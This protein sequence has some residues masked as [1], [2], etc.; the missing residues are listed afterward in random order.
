MCGIAGFIGAG[1]QSDLARMSDALVHRGP[2]G[3]GTF[4]DEELKVFLAH[5]RLAILDIAGGEQPMW[6]EDRKVC[7]T[8]NG[9]I[10]NAPEL[11][12]ELERAGH[13][14]ESDH[15][16]TE[17]LVH[18]W[19]QWGRDLPAKLNG[20]FA[21]A[22]LDRGQ[23][24]LFLARDRFGEKPLYYTQ[25]R[26]FFGF[27]SEL[28]SLVAHSRVSK[29][30][31]P[32]A[33]CKFFAYGYIP[34]PNAIVEG[35][36]KLPGGYWLSYNFHTQELITR[37]YWHFVIEPDPSITDAD[38]P[39]LIEE[40]RSLLLS[41]AQRRLVSDVPIGSFLSGGLDSSLVLASLA[42]G[43]PS[44]DLSTFTIGFQEPS[45]DES[46]YA[47]MVAAQFGT[48]HHERRL[49]IERARELIPEVLGRLDE[50]LG[51]ASLLPTYLLSAFTRE[52]VKVALTGDGGDE[53]FAGYDPF[54]ALNPAAV[55]DRL[56]PSWAHRSVRRLVDLLP[57]SDANMTMDF[58]LRRTLM[59]IEAPAAA[60][61]P[62]WMAP[63]DPKDLK[64]A[65]ESALDVREIYGE[66][67]ELWETD[68]SKSTT[69]R[70][71][72]FFTRFYL[73]DDI[74]AKADRAS[75]MCS[76]ETRAV[77]LDNDL[78]EFCRRLPSRFKYRNGERKYLLKKVARSMLPKDI[79][80]RKKKGFGIPLAKWLRSFPGTV[81][82]NRV[83]GM[84]TDFAQRAFEQH[85]SGAADYRL[86]LWSWIVLQSYISN[87]PYCSQ[88]SVLTPTAPAEIA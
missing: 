63:L 83:P 85:R 39:R 12:S 6:N 20:M 66:A 78:V 73:Q 35:T 68:T 53:L 45:F 52:H 77:F 82:L 65:F 64:D 4:V 72:E 58:K 31:N 16:D 46:R 36:N 71:L 38:E 70:A 75:M 24:E 8:F 48:R 19:E 1:T 25:R 18:G 29:S 69:D 7:V 51:D 17:V 84:R 41:A 28:K 74:L 5:R 14:F 79:V 22:I 76:L 23:A 88:T 44:K 3:E 57:F 37:S 49:S 62:V 33:L 86:F 87:D 9:E 67:I 60:R 47:K 10:Y 26:D 11:R 2:D 54:V 21:F 42:Q 55:Y 81:P 32:R 40:C 80:E 30:I 61:L 13:R 34:A 27:S 50:P 59:G 15:S 56:V 43:R